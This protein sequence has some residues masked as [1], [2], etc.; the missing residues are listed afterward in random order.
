MADMERVDAFVVEFQSDGGAALALVTADLGFAIA[1]RACK[2]IRLMAVLHL[3]GGTGS[4]VVTISDG[5]TDLTD[6]ISILASAAVGTI[7]TVDVR[8]EDANAFAINELM[9]ASSDGGASTGGFGRLYA[10]CRPL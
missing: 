10:V 6:T 1:P 4:A 3:G 5:V 9:R 2:I 8:E 7:P